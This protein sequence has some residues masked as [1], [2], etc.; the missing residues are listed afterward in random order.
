MTANVSIVVAEATNTLRIANSALR[1]R[2]PDELLPKRAPEA[3]APGMRR[4][5]SGGQA[6]DRRRAPSRRLRRS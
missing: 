1:A 3:A 6:H 2:I 4:R 5:R